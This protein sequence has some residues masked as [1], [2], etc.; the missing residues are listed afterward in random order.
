MKKP[1]IQRHRRGPISLSAMLPK[2][3]GR[4]MRRRGFAEAAIV[5][6]W[7]EIVGHALAEETLPLKFVVPRGT[8]AGGILH[9]RVNG[10]F[11]TELQH[12][13]PT[14]IERINGYFGY[15]AVTRLTLIQGPIRPYLQRARRKTVRRPKPADAALTGTLNSIEDEELRAAL[16]QLGQSVRGDADPPRG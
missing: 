8:P 16:A 7:P 2:L 14:V 5:A 4:A 6:E 9:V 3:A 15:A 11:A 12:L 10:A 1:E 13:A